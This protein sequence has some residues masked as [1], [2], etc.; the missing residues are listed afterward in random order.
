[1][2]SFYSILLN[3][4]FY[5]SLVEIIICLVFFFIGLSRWLILNT[6]AVLIIVAPSYFI[7]AK[8]L[9]PS[10]II[11][12]QIVG[13]YIFPATF[14]LMIK[15]QYDHYRHKTIAPVYIFSSICFIL[16]FV[17]P[18][19][20]T[21]IIF[22]LHLFFYIYILYMLLPSRIDY[23]LM[24]LFAVITMNVFY[25]SISISTFN[26]L[27]FIFST[28]LMSIAASFLFSVNMKS[29][30]SYLMSQFD[31]V[32]Q[33]N[34]KLNHKI[35]RLRQSNDSSRKIILEKD[36]ELSQMSRHAS[37]A[38]LTTGIAHEL[39]QPL[40]GIKGIAQ[41]MIDDLNAEEFE[42]LQGVSELLKICAL[43]DKSSMIIDHIR[44]F[45]KKSSLT[46]KPIDLNKVI[47]EAI[48]LINIQLKKNN[49]DLIFVLDDTIPKILGDKISLEQ[50]IVNMIMNSR[51]AILEKEIDSSEEQGKIR[52]TTSSS[53]S[54]VT[55]IIQDNGN[56]ISDEIIQKIWSPFFTTKNRELG[57]GVG[58]SL[59]NKILKDHNAT[60]TVNSDMKGTQFSINFPANDE[61][62]GTNIPAMV[63]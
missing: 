60:V 63:L 23:I 28:G 27:H 61:S 31:A 29:R 5:T 55:M 19:S 17:F 6:L 39:A 59:C 9:L 35:A 40:T 33:L 50:L 24:A 16:H 44:N 42:N 25:L 18:G 7:T 8:L 11:L 3:F 14:A 22:I 21:L 10:D 26:I 46:I 58:L 45:S 47:L 34:S 13:L 49:I 20:N 4:I 37:L 62:A 38:E 43:V 12:V 53:V 41:N 52:I 15:S 48:D 2:D 32:N 30:I 56:G 57:T 36:I 54:M 51:D 1:M